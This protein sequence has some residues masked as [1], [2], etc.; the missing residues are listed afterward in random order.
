[1]KKSLFVALAIL[2]NATVWSSWV[3]VPGAEEGLI[4]YQQQTRGNLSLDFSL[5]GYE[6]EEITRDGIDYTRISY[7]EEGKILAI[8]MPDLP[9]FTRLI[10]IP[11]QGDVTLNIISNDYKIISDIVI[12]PQEELLT[13]SEPV[14]DTYTRNNEYYRQGGIFPAQIATVGEPA[15]MRDVRLVKVTF[16]PFSYDA[17]KRELHVYENISVEVVTSGRGGINTIE[18]QKAPSRAFTSIFESSIL[19]YPEIAATR[20]EFQRPAILFIYPND[21]NVEI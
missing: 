5:N 21:N 10:A 9:V 13:E 12:Y 15:I 16:Y 1:M 19:N 17:E 14:R 11:D 4:S 20:D 8:G 6:M 3:D 2:L 7:P 18:N